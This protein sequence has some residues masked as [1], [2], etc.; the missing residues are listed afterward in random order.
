MNASLAALVKRRL[1]SREDAM[2]ASMLPDELARLLGTALGAAV[3]ATA[4]PLPR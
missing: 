3:P 1:I 4:T 2:A